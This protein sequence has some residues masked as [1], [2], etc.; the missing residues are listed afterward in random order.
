MLA[1]LPWPFGPSKKVVAGFEA[2]QRFNNSFE[3]KYGS[4]SP[5]VRGSYGDARVQARSSGRLLVIYLH[6]PQHEDS[7]AFCSATLASEV[8]RLCLQENFES[9]AGSIEYSEPYALMNDHLKPS[10]FPFLAVLHC[11]SDNVEYC[12]DRLEGSFSAE[13]LVAR[14]L[15]VKEA[16][17]AI[18]D[19]RH[20]AQSERREAVSLR[21]EQ[22][23]E[24]ERALEADRARAAEA[25]AERARKEEQVEN[26]AAKAELDAALELSLQLSAEANLRRK[27]EALPPE[28]PAGPDATRL[29]LQLPNGSK[30]DRRFLA[31]APLSQVRDF[32]DIYFGDNEIRIA[33]Y[34]LCTRVPRATYAD[35]SV[36]LREAGLHPQSVLFV[37]DLDA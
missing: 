14:L 6:S 34:S 9:W 4:A 17:G 36:T 13:N 1:D 23:V 27:R 29:R 31:S 12:I 24:F 7:D 19:R 32:V 25:Q 5:F 3:S 10:T 15:A 8:V 2:A 30:I 16:H 18:L 33:S 35:G 37:Q 21:S 22:D 28:P 20:R 11:K 26:E